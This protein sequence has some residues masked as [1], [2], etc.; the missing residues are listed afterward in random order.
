MWTR[1]GKQK[2]GNAGHQ[3]G[4]HERSAGAPYG[5][6]GEGHSRRGNNEKLDPNAWEWLTLDVAAGRLDRRQ[7]TLRLRKLVP[8][9]K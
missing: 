3:V 4:C 6:G 9:A 2:G 7:T 8:K 1:A 5:V